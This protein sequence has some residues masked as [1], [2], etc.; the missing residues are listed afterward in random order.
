MYILRELLRETLNAIQININ[1][2]KR[3]RWERSAKRLK[4]KSQEIKGASVKFTR[5]TPVETWSFL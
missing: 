3:E 2:K 1:A 4:Y 5:F